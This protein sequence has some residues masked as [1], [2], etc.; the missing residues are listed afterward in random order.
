M[1]VGTVLSGDLVFFSWAFFVSFACSCPPHVQ[2]PGS[3]MMLRR[4]CPDVLHGERPSLHVCIDSHEDVCMRPPRAVAG[5]L[6]LLTLQPTSSFLRSL[7]A[8]P[9]CLSSSLLFVP[10]ASSPCPSCSSSVNLRVVCVYRARFRSQCSF[11][12]LITCPL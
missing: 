11:Y 5:V 7:P 1:E 6:K 2:L 12:F 9:W 3:F 4:F 8:L 10:R